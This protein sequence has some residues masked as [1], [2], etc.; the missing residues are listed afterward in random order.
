MRADAINTD[1]FAFSRVEV[2]A[3]KRWERTKSMGAFSTSLIGRERTEAFVGSSRLLNEDADAG[4]PRYSRALP[5][6]AP[7]TTRASR[8]VL[9]VLPNHGIPYQ[10]LLLSLI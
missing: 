10:P 9:S 8:F 7:S 1:Q 6:E 5:E 2:R 4:T 3:E